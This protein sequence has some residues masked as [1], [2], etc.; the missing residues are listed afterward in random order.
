MRLPYIVLALDH[1]LWCAISVSL[2]L[3]SHVKICKRTVLVKTSSESPGREVID[4]I[5]MVGFLV[6]VP[7]YVTPSRLK[8]HQQICAALLSSGI[9]GIF[10]ILMRCA[11]QVAKTQSLLSALS[12]VSLSC[13]SSL[14]C[15]LTHPAS[16]LSVG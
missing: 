1:V 12:R 7:S 9:S 15:C 11:W 6:G 16:K 8:V 13:P 10:V 4:K 2:T 14:V 5:A 3:S